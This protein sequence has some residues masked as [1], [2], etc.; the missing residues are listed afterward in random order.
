MVNW[1]ICKKF[2]KLFEIKI[3]ANN[4]YL[5]LIFFLCFHFIKSYSCWSVV[6]FLLPLVSVPQLQPLYLIAPVLTVY[7]LFSFSPG[8]FLS[9]DNLFFFS[10]DDTVCCWVVVIYRV[11]IFLLCDFIASKSVSVGMP[12]Q[13]LWPSTPAKEASTSW[14]TIRSCVIHW[15]ETIVCN[16]LQAGRQTNKNFKKNSQTNGAFCSVCPAEVCWTS[17]VESGNAQKNRTE[18]RTLK[19]QEEEGSDVTHE[20]PEYTIILLKMWK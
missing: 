7:I 12:R 11:C 8:G 14:S 1:L 13:N 9:L 18:G 4:T 20:G 15:A 5:Y 10:P 2:N 16:S 6:S 17:C 19:I 3:Q